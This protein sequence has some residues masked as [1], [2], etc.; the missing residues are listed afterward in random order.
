MIVSTTHI[1]NVI[2]RIRNNHQ[3]EHWK[4]HQSSFVELQRDLQWLVSLT[5]D[6]TLFYLSDDEMEELTVVL[7]DFSAFVLGIKHDNA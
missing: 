4:S 1:S 6:Q 5:Q 7:N 3:S 2:H